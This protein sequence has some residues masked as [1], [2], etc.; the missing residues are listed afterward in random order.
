MPSLSK[1]IAED[2][3]SLPEGSPIC[4]GALL[5]L[6][7]RAAVDQA[8][9]RLARSGQ[10]LRICQGVYMR[11]V[12]TRFGPCAPSVE[13]AVRALAE[14][15][16]ETIVPSGGAAA[17]VLGLTTQVPVR[18]VYLTSGRGRRL[19][20]TNLR[21]DLRHAPR[22]QLVAPHRRAGDVVRAL[23]W[24]GPGEVQSALQRLAPRLTPEDVGELANARATMPHWMAEPVSRFLPHPHGS[25]IAAAGPVSSTMCSPVSARSAR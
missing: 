17:H 1:R 2:A 7:N 25:R 5:H 24:L 8:L 21:V 3:R 22:W 15:W 19:H 11:P 20:F 6:G 12:E 14:L 13:K 18:P 10:L 9:S 4:P 23:A 16:S